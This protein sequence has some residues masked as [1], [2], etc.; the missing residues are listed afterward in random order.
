[1]RDVHRLDIVA[2]LDMPLLAQTPKFYSSSSRSSEV[3]LSKIMYAFRPSDG[4]ELAVGRD[5]LPDGLNNQNQGS[6]IRESNLMG[7]SDFPTQLKAFF[8]SEKFLISPYVFGASG[9]E[10]TPLREKG[11]GVLGEWVL[12]GSFVVGGISV[13]GSSS[14]WKRPAYGADNRSR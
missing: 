6:F 7:P 13:Y 3:T 4:F 1:M 9:L 12:S 11:A 5:A 8:W 14:T 2:E 10:L